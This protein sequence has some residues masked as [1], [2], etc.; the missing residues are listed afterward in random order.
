LVHGKVGER[1]FTVAQGASDPPPQ[2]EAF[3]IEVAPSKVH[4]FDETTG[5]R[6][7]SASGNG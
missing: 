1:A 2:G 6:L 7:S 5:A 3:I 4:L